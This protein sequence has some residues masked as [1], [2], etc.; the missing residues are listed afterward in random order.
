MIMSSV[1]DWGALDVLEAWVNCVKLRHLRIARIA[2]FCPEWD[3]MHAHRVAHAGMLCRLCHRFAHVN[4][5]SG[6]LHR[7]LLCLFEEIGPNCKS[8][9]KDVSY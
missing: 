7:T 8:L 2:P 3:H 6:D 5:R 9:P 4:R 1:F